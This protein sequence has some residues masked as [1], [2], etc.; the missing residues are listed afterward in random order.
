[1]AKSEIAS[2]LPHC[3]TLRL[4]VKKKSLDY[5]T[6][7][8]AQ[9]KKVCFHTL[10][11]NSHHG[12]DF[13]LFTQFFRKCDFTLWVWNHTQSVISHFLTYFTPLQ[14]WL[15]WTEEGVKMENQKKPLLIRPS[16]TPKT[17]P[18]KNFCPQSFPS[19]GA[20]TWL[21]SCDFSC[22]FSKNSKSLWIF[23]HI[24]QKHIKIHTQ[25]PRAG[26]HS[27]Q[28]LWTKII[29]GICFRGPRGPN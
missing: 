1:M 13:T 26:A 19:M 8:Q 12:C 29:F 11:V 20:S 17:N 22:D 2:Y 5:N 15:H 3:D 4:E 16:R 14:R 9:I 18:D 25:K 28:R 21:S 24:L 23:A 7:G 10:S 6:G 27:R